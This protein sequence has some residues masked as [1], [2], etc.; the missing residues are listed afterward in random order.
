MPLGDSITVGYT[1][2]PEWSVPFGFGYRAPLAQMVQDAGCKAIFVGAS[3][4]PWDDRFGLPRQISDKTLLASGMDKHRGYGGWRL[5]QIERW[6]PLW[7]LTDRPDIVLLMAGTNDIKGG[8]AEAPLAAE[9]NLRAV[10][11]TIRFW[12]PSAQILIAQI[13]AKVEPTPAIETFNRYVAS[14]A[15]EFR[16]IA[17]DQYS[18]FVGADGKPLASAFSNGINHPSPALYRIM[19]ERWFEKLPH[20]A[21][22]KL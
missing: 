16:L 10:V 18:I 5:A 22:P 6:L 9:E 7:L 17:V 21:C 8:S 14:L 11:E 15:G 20:S 19:A 2:N 13:P 1:D 4:E 12:R 3:Q